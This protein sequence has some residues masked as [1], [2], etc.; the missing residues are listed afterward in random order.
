MIVYKLKFCLE[1]EKNVWR[2]NLTQI[3]KNIYTETDFLIN[4][5]NIAKMSF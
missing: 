1:N 3:R 4:I 2:S 5:I